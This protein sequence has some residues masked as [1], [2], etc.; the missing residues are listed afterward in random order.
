MSEQ[1][2]RLAPDLSPV[3]VV[4]RQSEGG[5]GDF[6]Q[7]REL[8]EVEA[9]GRFREYMLLSWYDRER[10]FESPAHVSECTGGGP[11]NGY[12]FYALNRGARL[13]VEID[14]GRFIFFYTP[15]EW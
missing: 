2:C 13:K 3:E 12:I 6:R 1:K 9:A 11:K 14:A 10:D 15:V 7:A 4:R 8:A 5:V